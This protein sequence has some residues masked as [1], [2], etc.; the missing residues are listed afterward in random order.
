MNALLIASDHAGFGLK[1]KLRKYLEQKG[2]EV[3]DLG[4]YSKERCDYPEYAYKLAKGIA[5]G[6]Y[7]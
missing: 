1:E 4:T 3:K 5:S 2:V 6:E 7:K